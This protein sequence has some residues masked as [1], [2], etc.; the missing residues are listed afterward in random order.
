MLEVTAASVDLSG[1]VDAAEPFES[2]KPAAI[3][4]PVAAAPAPVVEKP[5]A[6]KKEPA[7]APAPVAAEAADEDLEGLLGDLV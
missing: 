5:K 6:A 3:A 1:E 7:P 2:P 4:A